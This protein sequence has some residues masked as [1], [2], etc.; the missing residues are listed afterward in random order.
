MD[1]LLAVT[2]NSVD[3]LDT[4]S[5]LTFTGSTVTLFYNLHRLLMSQCMLLCDYTLAHQ[6]RH[7]TQAHTRGVGEPAGR[8]EHS[9]TTLF[10]TTVVETL[11]VILW[12]DQEYNTEQHALSTYSV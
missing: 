8:R 1:L 7:V 6:L 2:S 12:C 5:S 11:S 4:N 3:S 9:L 10:Q